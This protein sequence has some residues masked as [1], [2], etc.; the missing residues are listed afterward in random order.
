MTKH[1]SLDG[2][3]QVPPH[4]VILYRYTRD[5]TSSLLDGAQT[6]EWKRGIRLR[7]ACDGEKQRL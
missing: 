1:S 4:S 6:D 7:S 3:A 5:G 2:V